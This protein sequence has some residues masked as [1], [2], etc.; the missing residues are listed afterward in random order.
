MKK[1][2]A[3]MMALGASLLS[4]E[5]LAAPRPDLAVTIA[6]PSG[7]YVYESAM[8]TV[9]VSNVGQKDAA[10]VA[11]TIQLPETHTSPQVYIMGTLGS[12][13]ASCVRSGTKLNCSLGTIVKGTSKSVTYNLAVPFSTAPAM[14]SASATTITT[15][16]NLA[17]NS[18]SFDATPLT[19][20][21][22]VNAPV[23]VSNRHCTGQGLS[24]FYECELFPS[25][26]SSFDSVLNADQTVT[27]TD[28]PS[29]WGEWSLVEP[30]HLAIDYYDASGLIGSLDAWGT[31]GG[32]FEGPMVFPA[33]SYIAMYEVCPL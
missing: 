25:S 27:I 15:E 3:T 18:A 11:L 22:D 20:D 28:E 12:F 4:A 19:Y 1:T 16:T 5:A 10:S 29:A 2:F 6:G 9:T 7:N 32:C 8:T 33:S 26:I 31:G 21:T 14:V 17:N 30:D 23:T 13:S 24:S